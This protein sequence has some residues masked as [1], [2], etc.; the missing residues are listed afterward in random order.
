MQARYYDP[1][2]G[3]FY[4]NDP[5]GVRD[6]FSFNR[7]AYARNNPYKYIDPDGRAEQLVIAGK[8]GNINTVVTG[9]AKGLVVHLGNTNRMTPPIVKGVVAHEEF[10]IG[11]IMEACKS[12]N[13]SSIYTVEEGLIVTF[14]E[15][16]DRLN[17]ELDAYDIEIETLEGLEKNKKYRKYRKS[18]QERI[19]QMRIEKKKRERERKAEEERKKDEK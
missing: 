17:K 19:K 13:C 14:L 5:V 10:H 6:I 15:L 4:S 7:Y 16:S 1:V 9:G 11:Q 2:I 12:Q 3:R 18:I 8:A